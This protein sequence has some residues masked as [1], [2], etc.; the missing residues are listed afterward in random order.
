[1]DFINGLPIATIFF[2]VLVIFVLYSTLKPF[3]RV[4]TGR[5]NVLV[6]TLVH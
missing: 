3:H 2:I 4:I 1:M 6:A 5:L